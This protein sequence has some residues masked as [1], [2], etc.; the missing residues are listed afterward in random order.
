[1]IKC[2]FMEIYMETIVDLLSESRQAQRTL[3]IRE[4]PIN[5]VYVEGL[6]E[7]KV[8]GKEE[9]FGLIKNGAR[10]RA[11]NA[12]MMNKTSSRS[13]AILQV[14]LQQRYIETEGGVK[15][16]SDLFADGLLVETP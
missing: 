10:A 7:K 11:T 4:D 14:S 3:H 16:V 12:T 9:M 6:T 5:G 8:K 15:K 2:V 13:H 1:M